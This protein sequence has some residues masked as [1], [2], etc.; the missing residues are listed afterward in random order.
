MA[1]TWNAPDANHKILQLQ[2]RVITAR[3]FVL[4]LG[5]NPLKKVAVNRNKFFP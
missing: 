2:A 5:V 3:V 1:N 4:Q